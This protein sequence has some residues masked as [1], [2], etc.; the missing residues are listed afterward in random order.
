MVKL[1]W[2]QFHNQPWLPHPSVCGEKVQGIA[3]SIRAK[4]EIV[5]FAINTGKQLQKSK[6]TVTP[7]IHEGLLIIDAEKSRENEYNKEIRHGYVY[8]QIN[9]D[10]KQRSKCENLTRKRTT[11][12]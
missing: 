11:F 4:I 5:Y 3:D 9:T 6:F 2:L 10:Q 8:N 7:C 12:V 1:R